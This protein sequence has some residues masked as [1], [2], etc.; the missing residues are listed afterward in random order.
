MKKAAFP[1]LLLL[2]SQLLT[3]QTLEWKAGMYHFFDNTEFLGSSYVNDQTMAGIRFSPEIGLGMNR[4]HHF[5]I[6][7]DALKSYGSP[8]FVD[9]CSPTA[10]YLYDNGH[11]RFMMGSFAREGQLNDF[12]RAFFQ[13]S[14]RYFRPNM[15]GFLLA[16]KDEGLH[17]K[18][19]LDWTGKQSF[20]VHEAFFVGGSVSYQKSIF[21]AEAQAYMFHHA[22]SLSI[23]GVRD[24]ILMHPA[25]GLDLT[26]H[27]WLD[28]LRFSVGTLVGLE[29]ERRNSDFFTSR[30]GW[31]IE[32]DAA[33]KGFGLNASTYMGQGIMVDYAT[34]G[35]KLYWGD[36][37][38]RGKFYS[39][40][41][42][43][44]DF[45]RLPYL[46]GK[47][48][49]ANHFSEGNFYVEQSLIIQATLGSNSKHFHGKK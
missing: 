25:I 21:V 29:R 12:S 14:I 15:N 23:R 10:Y 33:F 36:P 30:K 37:L 18:L 1:V 35:N 5:R 4:N 19:F 42:L 6:G 3:A 39:R 8:N 7:F 22:G 38:Y 11:F 34:M 43:S 41:D 20:T 26:G 28:S 48:N 9:S 49:F 27:T 45:L 24:N 16:Y 2:L 31:M 32:L 13:D 17:A 40:I 47:V 46:T 44:Y